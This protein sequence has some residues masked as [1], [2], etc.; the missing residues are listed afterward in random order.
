MELHGD[1]EMVRATGCCPPFFFLSLPF[2]DFARSGRSR[3]APVARRRYKSGRPGGISA[4][5]IF[6]FPLPFFLFSGKR[7]AA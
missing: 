2:P 4:V 3:T 1:W 5:A 6:F 7:S